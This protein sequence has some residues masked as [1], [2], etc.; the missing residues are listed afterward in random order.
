[1]R[2][3]LHAISS[4]ARLSLAAAKRYS[5]ERPKGLLCSKQF[6]LS[7]SNQ[8]TVGNNLGFD[9]GGGSCAALVVAFLV[10]NKIGEGAEFAQW[11]S[12]AQNRRSKKE[13][14]KRFMELINDMQ[15]A[16]SET[17]YNQILRVRDFQ[18]DI[19]KGFGLTFNEEWLITYRGTF[20]IDAVDTLVDHAD[21]SPHHYFTFGIWK[22]TTSSESGWGH[23]IG[24][25]KK[26]GGYVLYDPNV[27]IYTCR[28]KEGLKAALRDMISK[29][30]LY[31]GS[32]Y[33]SLRPFAES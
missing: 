16:Y 28:S 5:Q 24:L 29:V 23:S 3:S 18:K 9:V 14:D 13:V 4:G 12:D 11:L 2:S 27:G 26:D 25:L 33:W 6:D 8:S 17:G 20:D 30:S 15:K 22:D 31:R 32:T 10:Y 21:N 1:M 19:P 7:P